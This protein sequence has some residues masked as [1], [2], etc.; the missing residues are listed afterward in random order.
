MMRTW[1]VSFFLPALRC[2][3]YI[4]NRAK[5][6]SEKEGEKKNTGKSAKGAAKRNRSFDISS[7]A[8]EGRRARVFGL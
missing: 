6:L 2:T 4:Q 5:Q 7:D 8:R 1:V 3:L